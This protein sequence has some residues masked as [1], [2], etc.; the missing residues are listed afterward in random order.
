MLSLECGVK[1]KLNVQVVV[2]HRQVP[3]QLMHLL[4]WVAIMV[5]ALEQIRIDLLQEKNNCP[6]QKT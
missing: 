5:S 6:Q 2:T 4:S 1:L 3:K